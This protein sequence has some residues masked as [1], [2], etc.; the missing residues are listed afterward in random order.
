MTEHPWGR[1]R[2]D[3]QRARWLDR[4]GVYLGFGLLVVFVAIGFLRTQ[5][6][7]DAINHDRKI[8]IVDRV[9]Q[10]KRDAVIARDAF[11]FNCVK[12]QKAQDAAR[13]AIKGGGDDLASIV[14]EFAHPTTP[15]GVADLQAIVNSIEGHARTRA[16]T[17]TPIDCSYPPR[18]P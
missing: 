12:L 9:V 1:R 4:W 15:Q 18:A 17:L 14:R 2:G 13:G 8:R 16:A 7:I 3:L 10:D 6:A 11:V 5:G